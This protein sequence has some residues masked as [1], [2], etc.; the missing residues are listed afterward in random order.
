MPHLDIKTAK[1][2]IDDFHYI[3]YWKIMHQLR[4]ENSPVSPA[5]LTSIA[6]FF[7]SVNQPV[8]LMQAL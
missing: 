3:N 4:K 6:L 2:E 5:N 1:F 8:F 7:N